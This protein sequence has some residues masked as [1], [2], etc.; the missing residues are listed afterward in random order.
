[1]SSGEK[2]QVRQ[3][4]PLAR[5]P[6]TQRARGALAKT[7][8]CARMAKRMLE[9]ELVIAQVLGVHEVGG[10][11]WRHSYNV[12]SLA[13]AGLLAAKQVVR[14]QALG[15]FKSTPEMGS[16]R[17]E[18]VG[19]VGCVNAATGLASVDCLLF[20]AQSLV[21]PLQLPPLLASW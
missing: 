14:T 7:G 15:P 9:L 13:N 12:A 21:P 11:G 4:L 18:A 3:G 10:G 1:M 16:F 2:P 19:V 20:L 8:Q 5:H 17:H 6:C